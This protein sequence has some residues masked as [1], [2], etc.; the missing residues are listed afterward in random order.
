MEKEQQQNNKNRNKKIVSQVAR[1]V[2]RGADRWREREIK[3]YKRIK[4]RVNIQTCRE[5]NRQK[6]G[7]IY[8]KI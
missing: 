7:H 6:D 2:H 3:R 5:K 4:H 8:K 1:K